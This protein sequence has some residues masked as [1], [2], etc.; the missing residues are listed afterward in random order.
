MNLEIITIG[1]EILQGQVVNT[2]AAFLG[3]RLT[4]A[5]IQVGWMTVVGDNRQQMLHAF[6]RS[7]S[8]ARAVILTGGLGPTPDD[9]TKPCL[10][11]FFGDE[12]VFRDDLL[13]K[14]KKRFTDRGLEFP[15]ASRNQA[16]FPAG[17]RL[18]PNP[19]GTAAGI[20]YVRD[21]NEWFALPGIPVEMRAM[22]DGYVLPR[23]K[24]IGLSGRVAVRLLR[25]TGIPESLLMERL[26]R[27]IDAASLVEIAFLPRFYGVDLKLTGRTGG[28]KE[29]NRRLDQAEQLLLPDLEPYLYARGAESLPQVVGRLAREKGLRI[30]VAESCTGGLIAKLFS[31][32]PGSSDYFERGLVT[33]SNRSK[34]ELL[35]IPETLI[36]RHG[37]VSEPVARAMAQGLL[38]RSGANVTLAITGIAGPTGGTPEKPVGLVFI[39]V[40]DKK[41]CE[42]KEIRLSG[43]RETIRE[44][45]AAAA[46]KLLHDHI[47]R[48]D[49]GE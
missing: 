7:D 2:N 24:E 49:L 32:V 20:H 10:A 23:L 31:D 18:I 30:A 1:D 27:L 39:A 8:R 36:E 4:D 16:E 33:Y 9:L 12:L 41:G 19:N 44:R 29:I 11:E 35:G 45:A 13:E 22:V 43:Q 42:M 28:L 38:E 14:V 26:T 17:A 48:L 5:G 25:T 40:A 46:F 21:K 15:D 47:K 6:R 34:T 3:E 37:A